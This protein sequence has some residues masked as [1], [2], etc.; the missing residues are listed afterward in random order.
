MH[1]KCQV[2]CSWHEQCTSP[3]TYGILKYLGF[4][5]VLFL[6][7]VRGSLCSPGCPGTHFVDQAGLE[8]RN[9]P[10]SASRVLGLKACAT[11]AQLKYLVMN[12]I[13]HCF[14]F[15]KIMCV[16]LYVWGACVSVTTS[17]CRPEDNIWC[18]SQNCHPPPL[19]Q[20]VLLLWSSPTRLG[21]LASESQQPFPLYLPITTPAF[22]V[23]IL[24]GLRPSGLG[25]KHFPDWAICHSCSLV[26]NLMLWVMF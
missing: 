10:A 11:T 19:R 16:C 8:L 9:P 14:I 24:G 13:V 3:L 21:W 26:L 22:S 20:G 18:H 2:L 4:C 23:W 17:V 1:L 15:K 7:W 5:F 12:D 25:S 6:F